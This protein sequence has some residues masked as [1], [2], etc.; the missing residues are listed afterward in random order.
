MTM[1][2]VV[3]YLKKYTTCTAMADDAPESF[4]CPISMALMR[5][6]VVTSAG[7]TY[8]ALPTS[9]TLRNR[10]WLVLYIESLRQHDILL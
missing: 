1:I 8:V 4:L 2:K 3:N 10:P 7:Q 9:H 5:D 6:P